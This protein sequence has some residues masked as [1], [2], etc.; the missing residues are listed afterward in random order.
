ML[1]QWHDSIFARARCNRYLYID[2]PSRA[3]CRQHAFD[4]AKVEMAAVGEGA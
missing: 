4:R 1:V 2:V 3:Q